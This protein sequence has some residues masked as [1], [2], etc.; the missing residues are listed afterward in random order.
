[1]RANGCVGSEECLTIRVSFGVAALAIALVALVLV[2]PIARADEELV[3]FEAELSGDQ[4]VPPVETDASGEAFFQLSEDG[5][6]ITFQLSV[7]DISNVLAAHIHL[8]AAGTNGDVV[9]FLYGP[10]A[11]GGRPLEGVIATGTITAASLVGPLAGHPLSD[12]V[13]AMV[14]GNTYVNVH[15]SSFP[16]GEI[17][18]QIVVEDE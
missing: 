3:S 6:S 9:A 16:A 5:Q 2:V 15:T 12:L 14:G 7:D 4:Q 1:M 8:G 13:A 17:R 18:G 11:P 10:K